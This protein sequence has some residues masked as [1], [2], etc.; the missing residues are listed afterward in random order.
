MPSEFDEGI[1]ARKATYKPYA[2]A[3]PGGYMI[4]KRDQSPC[5]HGCPNHVNAHGYVA[6][7]AQGK[8]REA[9]EVI[10][11]T[12][13]FPGVIGRICPHPCEAACRR[14]EVDAPISICALKRFVAD[15]VDV[16]QLPVPEIEKRDERV[17]IIG[18]GPAGLTAAHFLALEGYQCTVFEAQSAAGGMLRVGIRCWTKR[19]GP[20]PDWGSRS[21]STVLWV[22]T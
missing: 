10:L 7:I 8:Y 14:G 11:R 2:Q 4:D 20:S 16:E 12:L 19:S 3:I 1:G 9:M 21:N 17:A 13:P 18:S 6:L 5:T 22:G 15:Q